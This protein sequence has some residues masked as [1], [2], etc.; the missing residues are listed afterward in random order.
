MRTRRNRCGSRRSSCRPLSKRRATFP[1]LC[2]LRVE[3]LEERALL[4]GLGLL[5]DDLTATS[6]P[7]L[8]LDAISADRSTDLLARIAS[9]PSGDSNPS[10]VLDS[11]C[12]YV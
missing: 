2:S 7:P 3:F 4:D 1:R 11:S 5:P 10:T 8:V 12:V 9:S 6:E